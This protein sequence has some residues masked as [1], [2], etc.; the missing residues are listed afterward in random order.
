[1]TQCSLGYA[2]NA[3]A[4]LSKFKITA[5]IDLRAKLQHY[6]ALVSQ[7]INQT[8]RRVFASEAVPAAEKLVS[9]FE[10]HTAILVKGRRKTHYGHTVCVT[11]GRSGLVLA[12]TV[13]RGNTADSAMT[14]AAVWRVA[15]LFGAV[16][17]QATFDAGFASQANQQALVEMGVTDAAFAKNSAI[18]VL[19]SVTSAKVHRALQRLRAGIEASISWLKRC[20]GFGRCSSRGFESFR[21]YAWASVLTVNLL[22]M[23][24]LSV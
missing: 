9:L 1:V 12:L 10:P 15:K 8:Q 23:S 11:T 17:E 2:H 3:I 13:E 7:V 4:A 16:P 20:F 5:A 14:I 24:R 6:A 18:D 19:Q 21:A 22:Q